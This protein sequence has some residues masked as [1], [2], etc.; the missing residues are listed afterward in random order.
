ME[1]VRGSGRIRVARAA[2][3]GILFG[4]MLSA[5]ALAR[6]AHGQSFAGEFPVPTAGASP[7]AIVSGPDGNL[8]FTESLRHQLGQITPDG[9]ITES[10][11][12]VG[13]AGAITVGSDHNLWFTLRNS[14]YIRRMTTQGEFEDFRVPAT[15]DPGLAGITAG[16]DGNLWF[17]EFNADKIGRMTTDGEVREFILPRLLPGTPPGVS[18]NIDR[19]PLDIVAGPDGNLW[20]TETFANMIGRI[21]PQG[22]ITEF[23]IPEGD[24]PPLANWPFE[25]PP[26]DCGLRGI[27]AGPDGNLWFVKANANKIGRITTTGQVSEFLIPSHSAG[28]WAITSGP[29]GNVWF[30]ESS[31]NKIGRIT[32]D[33]VIQEFVI[34]TDFSEPR[35]ITTGPDGYLWFTESAGN[36]IGRLTASTGP[37]VADSTTLCLRDRFK[38]QLTWSHP[39]RGSGTGKAIPLTEDTGYFWFFNSANVE[40]VIKALDGRSINGN[41]W[42]FYGALSSTQYTITVTDTVTGAVK[43]YENP[44]GTLA[45]VADTAAFGPAHAVGTADPSEIDARSDE[46]L[47]ALHAEL[48]Q[49]AVAPKGVAAN[50]TPGSTTLCLNQSRFQV[51]VDWVSKGRT[52]HGTAIPITGDTGYF[53]F[54]N[55]DNV[56]L[57]IKVL[58]GRGINGHF[59][60]FYGAL[61]NVGY[62]ITITD[63]ET[64]AVKTY[65][66]PEGALASVADTEA[67]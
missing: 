39:E 15:S 9:V 25:N 34:P 61:S 4:L 49:A 57:V 12:P 11:I 30:T 50:C 17:T 40:I 63:T 55:P 51:S 54:F 41:Y 45:S 42:V 5:G 56:E 10:H 3:R 26:L 28:A 59:W 64:Q 32:P 58:D 24:C 1:R 67:F 53:Y 23:R 66:N 7:S 14:N 65:V 13:Q 44:A 27:T 6:V 8:W 33:G 52:G 36:K 21:T 37:C 62:T 2:R 48:T 35:G 20:F 22:S 47:Y 29:D 18:I 16:P 38:V 31:T 43:T 46:E 60:V 19:K